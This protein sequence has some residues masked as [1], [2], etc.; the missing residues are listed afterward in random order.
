M[1]IRL[2]VPLDTPIFVVEGIAFFVAYAIPVLVID[3]YSAI[4]PLFFIAF[5]IMIFVVNFIFGFIAYAIPVLIVG[6]NIIFRLFLVALYIVILVVKGGRGIGIKYFH[7]HK[8]KRTD[9]S[10]DHDFIFH[11]VDSLLI[12]LQRHIIK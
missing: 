9:K 8:Q 12:S 5:H 4:R 10:H 6:G 2:F 3:S 11:E 7:E 1:P